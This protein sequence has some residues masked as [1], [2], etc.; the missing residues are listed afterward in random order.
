MA[1]IH[2]A[3]GEMVPN[4]TAFTRWLRVGQISLVSPLFYRRKINSTFVS[5]IV[6]KIFVLETT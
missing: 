6:P 5:V 3:A 4:S 2:E 1:I